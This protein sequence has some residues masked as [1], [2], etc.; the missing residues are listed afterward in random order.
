MTALRAVPWSETQGCSARARGGTRSA[1]SCCGSTSSAGKCTWNVA[2]DGSLDQVVTVSLDRHVGAVAPALGGGDVVAAGPG[3]L[4]VDEDGSV[5]ELAPEG[6]RTDV[7]MNDGACDAHGRFCAGTMAYDESLGAG[8]LYRLELDGSCTTVLT[9][10]TI[11]NGI[12]WS[13]DGSTMYLND[14]GTGCLETFG[15]DGATGTITKRRTLVRSDQP[16]V[17]PDR[18]IS[19]RRRW[20]LGGVV[21]RERGQPLPPRTGRASPASSCRSSD[22]PRVPTAALSGRRCS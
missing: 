7:R 20:D 16:G 5:V 15:F 8:A 21:G 4:F 3:F 10:L 12:G 17:V 14:S 22:P 1:R 2:A 18:L 11:A 19:R 9:G 6:G 13:P